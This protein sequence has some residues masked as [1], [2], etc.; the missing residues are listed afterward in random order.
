M[1]D[2]NKTMKRMKAGRKPAFIRFVPVSTSYISLFLLLPICK[3]CL[4]VASCPCV[5][6]R[7]MKGDYVTR[8]VLSAF[9]T[10][11]VRSEVPSL[12]KM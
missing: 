10:V 9:A 1:K 3:P 7:E 6:T 5:S 12:L 11:S 8:P 2:P 4:M